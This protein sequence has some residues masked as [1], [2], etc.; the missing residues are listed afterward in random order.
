MKLFQNKLQLVNLWLF[1][2]LTS[3]YSFFFWKMTRIKTESKEK[4]MKGRK[5]KVRER[6]KK[7]W[8]RKKLTNKKIMVIKFFF[9]CLFIDH[10]QNFFFLFVIYKQWH[11]LAPKTPM[12]FLPC[13][14]L[15][16]MHQRSVGRA[17]GLCIFF[18]KG[19]S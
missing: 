16:E 17:G 1:S 14:F 4:K 15:H 18:G 9:C 8:K 5:E 2:W 12:R 19:G 11:L 3:G 7:V 6:K 13:L 10:Q